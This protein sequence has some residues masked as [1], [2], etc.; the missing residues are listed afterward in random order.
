M[1]LLKILHQ[2]NIY[3]LILLIRVVYAQNIGPGVSPALGDLKTPT[4]HSSG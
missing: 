1:H 2:G 4:P 3:T